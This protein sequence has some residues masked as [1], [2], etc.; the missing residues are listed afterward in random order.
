MTADLV[1]DV[2]NASPRELVGMAN[3]IEGASWVLMSAWAIAVTPPGNLMDSQILAAE[4]G[5]GELDAVY[6]MAVSAR[7]GH[8]KLQDLDEWLWKDSYRRPMAMWE[9]VDLDPFGALA[10]EAD[11][12]DGLR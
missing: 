10:L 8:W 5:V 11:F 1:A 12:V 9:R 6:A 2:H 7:L 4:F 3:A